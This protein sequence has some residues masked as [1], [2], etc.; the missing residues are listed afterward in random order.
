MS[1]PIPHLRRAP[2][3]QI[4]EGIASLAGESGAASIDLAMSVKA[5]SDL[6]ARITRALQRYAHGEQDIIEGG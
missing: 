2:V 6:D 3:V 5:L 4:S 1:G